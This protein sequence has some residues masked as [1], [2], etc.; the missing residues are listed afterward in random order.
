MPKKKHNLPP[1]PEGKT[2]KEIL[3][4]S[5]YC[6]FVGMESAVAEAYRRSQG[7]ELT[8]LHAFD[9]WYEK[10]CGVVPANEED[11]TRVLLEA[12]EKE[13]R[14][15][16]KALRRKEKELA[17]IEALL[18]LAKKAEVLRAGEL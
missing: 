11:K 6:R 13:R 10:E 12:R 17:K 9:R 4:I 18:T 2:V 3:L 7:I 14:K 1:L 8:E 16:E 15:L 5:R